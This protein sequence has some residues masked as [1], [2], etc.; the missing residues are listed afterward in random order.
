MVPP[1]MIMMGGIRLAD[2][3]AAAQ[4]KKPAQR[5]PALKEDEDEDTTPKPKNDHELMMEAIK[6]GITL[7]KG[8]ER[9]NRLVENEA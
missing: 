7:K 1:P 5:R 2:Q 8:I 6:G 4:L 9:K 3:L